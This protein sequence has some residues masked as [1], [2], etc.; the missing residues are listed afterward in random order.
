M[1]QRVKEEFW[2]NDSPEFLYDQIDVQTILSFG[3]T[4]HNRN[5]GVVFAV[6]TPVVGLGS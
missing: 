4:T 3:T 6:L 5:N 2:S 1:I